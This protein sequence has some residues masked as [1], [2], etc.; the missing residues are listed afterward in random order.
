MPH[1][2]AWP[3]GVENEKE[4]NFPLDS[5]NPSF[6]NNL[7]SKTKEPILHNLEKAHLNKEHSELKFFS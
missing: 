6:L 1:L 4:G 5:L 2:K 3:R 7:L